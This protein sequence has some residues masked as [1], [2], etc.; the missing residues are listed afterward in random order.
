MKAFYRPLVKAD[1]VGWNDS[2]V[3]FLADMGLKCVD[4]L[5]NKAFFQLGLCIGKRPG[6]FIIIPILLAMFFVTGYQRIKY[7]IDPEYLFSPVNGEGK[8]ERA[9]AE[10]F[11]PVNY[12][13]RFNVARITRAGEHFISLSERFAP[14]WLLPND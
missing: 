8:I 7:N 11:F 6:Y 13:S 2:R 9:V 1:K 3:I 4:D 5:L 12:S 10:S 14:L